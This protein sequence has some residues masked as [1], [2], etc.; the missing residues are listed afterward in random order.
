MSKISSPSDPI[1]KGLYRL[2]FSSLL[3]ISDQF[4]LKTL[5]GIKFEIVYKKGHK[6][7]PLGIASMPRN[8]WIPSVLSVGIACLNQE[9]LVLLFGILISCPAEI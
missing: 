4:N 6:S 8:W 9:I 2:K 7:L 5:S 3:Q 1:F